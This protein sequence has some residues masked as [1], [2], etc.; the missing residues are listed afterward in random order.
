MILTCGDAYS[1]DDAV[2]QRF[3]FVHP[4][5]IQTDRDTGFEEVGI[6]LVERLLIHVAGIEL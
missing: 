4:A 3:L 2:K 1:D 5:A 6:T